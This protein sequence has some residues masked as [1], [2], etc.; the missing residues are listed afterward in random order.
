[1]EKLLVIC[2][3]TG[4]GKTDTAIAL[5]KKFNGELVSADSRQVY[6][7]MD[8][9]TGK[10]IQK[11]EIRNQRSELRIKKENGK[12]IVNDIPIHLYDVK[13]PDERFSLAE[14]QQLA[15]ERIKDIHSRGKLPILVGGTG[16]YIQAV[17]EGLK[18]PKVAPNQELRDKLEDETVENLLVELEKVDPDYFQKVD[19]NNK[20]RVV[21]ALEVYHQT[22]EAF[23][24][25]QKKYKVPFETLKIGLTSDREE[26]YKR[27]DLRVDKWFDIGFVDEVKNLLETYSVEL[28]A[29][30]SL[31]YRQVAMYIKGSLGSAEAK[32]RIKFDYHGYIRR[33]LTWFKRDPS[34]YWFDISIKNYGD[35]VAELVSEWLTRS[36]SARI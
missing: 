18:I 15:L 4:T 28:P 10:E 31:G 3:P 13:K 30:S 23:S 32:Q 24:S 20:R 19:K 12:W 9:G 7:E 22:G 2:G 27:N 21:R 29:M 1:M 34:I 35:E 16:L 25:L 36:E 8:I 26:L 5:A 11:P 17:T 6:I 14:Y 33:Q